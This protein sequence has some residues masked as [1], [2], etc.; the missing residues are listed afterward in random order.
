MAGMTYNVNF[1]FMGISEEDLGE[2]RKQRI[3]DEFLSLRHEFV[4]KVN[5][6]YDGWN[7]AYTDPISGED[8]EKYNNYIMAKHKPYLQLVNKTAKANGFAVRLDNFLEE[9]GD[10]C[11][12]F[13]MKNKKSGE[14]VNC[15]VFLTLSPA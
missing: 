12:V 1:H 13:K 10:I 4:N 8:D 3:I 14:I 6:M 11:G 9:P 7:A 5:S 15:K 2:S